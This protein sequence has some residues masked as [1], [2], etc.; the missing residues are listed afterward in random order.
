MYNQSPIMMIS[1]DYLVKGYFQFFDVLH[2]CW[3]KGNQG[4]IGNLSNEI[5]KS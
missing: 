2:I 4:Q 5:S 1:N 3:K